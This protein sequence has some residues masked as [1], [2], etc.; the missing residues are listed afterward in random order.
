MGLGA[1]LNNFIVYLNDLEFQEQKPEKVKGSVNVLTYH[2]AKG[3][4]WNLVIMESLDQ[5]ELKQDDIMRKSFFGVNDMVT[6]LPDS[7]NLF[8]ERYILLLPWFMGSKQK[9]PDDVKQVIEAKQEYK[10]TEDKIKEEVKRLLYVGM[11][12]ARDYLVSVSYDNRPL[13]WIENIG[14]REM[15]PGNFN[16][17]EIDVWDS[18]KHAELEVITGDPEFTG[19]HTP[20]QPR[21]LTRPSGD[22]DFEERYV[23]PSKVSENSTFDVEVLEDFDKRIS[24]KT[25]QNTEDSDIGNCLHHIYYSYRRE[26]DQALAK[27]ESILRNLKMRS[28][29]PNPQEITDSIENLFQFLEKRYGPAVK[30]YKEL[31][32]QN[33]TENGQVIRGSIDLVWETKDGAVVVD[34]KSYPGGIDKIKNQED[35]HYAGIYGPQ[36]LTYQRMLETAGKNVLATCIYY[37]VMGVIAEIKTC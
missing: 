33:F 28:V 3:L 15:K 29:F 1:S 31:P 19:N 21:R 4:E 22:K 36:L 35:A 5:D 16:G 2:S 24:L 23:S 10:N 26:D 27:A 11:T 8:P 17:S 18:G 37:A 32:L 6:R 13:K 34:Y 30:I 12:R 14:G 7:E 20:E 9:I 25:D